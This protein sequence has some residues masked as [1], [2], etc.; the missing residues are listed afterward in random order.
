MILYE[1]SEQ[2][3]ATL[4]QVA[5]WKQRNEERG[6]GTDIGEALDTVD[7]LVERLRGLLGAIAVEHPDLS[8]VDAIGAA[9]K[10]KTDP[11]EDLCEVCGDVVGYGDPMFHLGRC[12]DHPREDNA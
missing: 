10:D 6:D 5:R 3:V 9:V 12:D 7:E 4:E 2:A 8:N 1:A 11:Y